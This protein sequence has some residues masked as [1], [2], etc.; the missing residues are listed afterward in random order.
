MDDPAS[1]VGVWSDMSTALMFPGQGSQTVGMGRDAYLESAAARAIF[2]LADATLGVA[3]TRLCFEGPEEVKCPDSRP[4]CV[5][6]WVLGSQ[7]PCTPSGYP[8]N[9]FKS[10]KCG[11]KGEWRCGLDLSTVSQGGVHLP[12]CALVW[13]RLQRMSECRNRCPPT[14]QSRTARATTTPQCSIRGAPCR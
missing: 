4:D 2:E 7:Q 6:T 8:C 11:R 14:L 1:E 3:L 13:A 12:S 9:T 10:I 5:A